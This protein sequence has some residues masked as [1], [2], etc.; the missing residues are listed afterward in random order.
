MT[1][2]SKRILVLGVGNILLRDEGVGVRV[3]ERLQ[4]EYDFPDN[5]QVLDGGTLGMRLMDWI[6]DADYLIVADA[7]RG[8]GTPGTIYRLTG[9]DVRKSLAFKDSMHQVDLIET[10][11]CCEIA[12]S[13]PETVVVGVE[14][15]DLS[16]WSDVLTPTLQ[17]RMDDMVAAVLQEIREAGGSFAKRQ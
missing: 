13:R 4:A 9:E 3:A 10:L 5:I 1:E 8:G 6:M 14:P 17:A 2:P 16:P 15:L 7:V 12:G 11:T